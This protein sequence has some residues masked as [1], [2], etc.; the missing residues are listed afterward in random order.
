MLDFD[1]IL[2]AVLDRFAA[3]DA[4][5]AAKA[6]AYLL[7]DEFQDI[8]E[9]Q[10]RLIAEWGRESESIFIIGDPDQSIYGFRGSDHRYFARFAAE[11]PGIR[12]VRLTQNYRST[13][14]VIA[15][16]RAV[17]AGK[18]AGEDAC[19]LA[20]TRASG[21][22]VRLVETGDEFAAAIFVAKEINRLVGGVDM[23]AAQARAAAR[24]AR[25][26]AGQ[27]RGFADIAVLYRTNRQAE[28]LEQCCLKEGIPYVVVGRDDFLAEKP[29][30]EA[31]AFFRFLLNPADT[32][33]LL[34]CLK[35]R[36]I[37]LPAPGRAAP[38]GYCPGNNAAAVLEKLFAA[39]PGPA[40]QADGRRDFLAMAEKYA[41][42]LR[43]EKPWRVID[44]WISDN[45]LAGTKC[46]ERLLH[47][48]VAHGAMA[49][50]IQNLT[51]GR[52]SDIV[53]SGSK[54]YT[55]DAVALMTVHAAKG[56]EFPVTFIC[57]ANDG[58]FPLRGSGGD[59][60]AAEE[61]RLF[62]VGMTRARDELIMVTSRTPS[63]FLADIA[64]GQLLRESAFTPRQYKQAGLFDS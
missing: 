40:G 25:P 62:Y 30:R 41:P 38:N 24:K 7:V 18:A 23:L 20:A 61:R 36:N 49:S 44:S 1:D 6:C 9:L 26:A 47:T 29:V 11:F 57:G 51:L 4:G 54:V 10:Y 55:P 50:F 5:D 35:A 43:T 37:A 58:L 34:F 16:A 45:A 42:L 63:P 3:G 19:L 2:R 15:A 52:E 56:L 8:N 39:A 59:C 13:P 33:S 28:A 46:M 48:S 21:A 60:D 22:K 31:L 27:P 12:C 14:E 17:I 53:R 64:A 32:A